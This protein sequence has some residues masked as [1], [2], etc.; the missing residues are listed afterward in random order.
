MGGYKFLVMIAIIILFFF[1]CMLRFDY[2]YVCRYDFMSP[3]QVS[4][5]KVMCDY[6]SEILN[7]IWESPK[8]FVHK[9]RLYKSPAEVNLLRKSCDVASEAFIKA[10][11]TSKPGRK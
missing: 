8:Q 7:K 3:V 9:L 1:V 10:M 2:V 5:H 4:V 6:L 11:S